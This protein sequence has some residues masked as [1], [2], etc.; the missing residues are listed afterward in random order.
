MVQLLEKGDGGIVNATGGRILLGHGSGGLLSHRLIK[1]VLVSRFENGTPLPLDDAGIFT[2]GDHRLAF[3]TDSFVV[4]PLFFPGG[5]IG[6]LAVCGTINDLCM[7]GARPLY[8]SLALII[9]E[10]FPI[11]ELQRI[12]ESIRSTSRKTGVGILTGDTKVV[13]KGA[14]DKLF[15]NTSGV[16]VIEEGFRVSGACAKPGDVVLISGTMGDHGITVLSK[17][18]GLQFDTATQ[19]DCASL[20][21]L[22]ETL[23]P[24]AP[25]IHVMRDPTRGGVATTLNEI[26]GQSNAGIDLDEAALPVTE[27][28]RAACEMLGYDPLYVAN[29]GK[30]LVVIDPSAAEEAL[31]LMHLHPLGKNACRIGDVTSDHVPRVVLHTV[32]GGKRIVDML[33]GEQLPRIC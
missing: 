13:A 22:L 29:E 4:D 19:S 33:A 17:R 15:I 24:L 25:K 5:D 26:A 9:E 10:G 27:G 8:L 30:M 23:K 6:T 21:G 16:G 7:M 1:D 14:A 18:E 3:S 2:V 28:V 12:V 32:T 20:H 11:A 31:R